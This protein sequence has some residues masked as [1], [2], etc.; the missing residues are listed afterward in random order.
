MN[1]TTKTLAIL[2]VTVWAG[3]IPADRAATNPVATD[4]GA[5]RDSKAST[6]K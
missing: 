3:P 1:L 6:R 5:G 2:F 4:P